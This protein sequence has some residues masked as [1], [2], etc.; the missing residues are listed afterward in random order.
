MCFIRGIAVRGRRRGGDRPGGSRGTDGVRV[1]TRFVAATESG[2]H[3]EY[4]AALVEASSEG[5]IL[6]ET[7]WVQW[8]DAPHRVLRSCV[9]AA[10]ALDGEHRR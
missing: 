10:E 7:F 5:T 6:T 8:S 3:L 4:V 2:A 1:G 9:E